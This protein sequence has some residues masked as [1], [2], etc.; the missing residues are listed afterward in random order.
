VSGRGWGRAWDFPV[1]ATNILICTSFSIS[2]NLYSLFYALRPVNVLQNSVFQLSVP[3]I[4]L[5]SCRQ[6]AHTIMIWPPS[7]LQTSLWTW[8]HNMP[9][10]TPLT[11]FNMHIIPQCRSQ[12]PCGLTRRSAV[13]RLLRL[14]VR[15]PPWTWKFVSCECCVLSGRSLCDGLI[16]RT[17]G[18]YRLWWVVVCNLETSWMRRPWPTVGCRA[19]NK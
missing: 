6:L 8:F 19:K 4:C 9:F 3:S 7:A 16:T 15:I 10:L 11:I 17:E 12:W 14:W 1:W 2:F 5:C 13:A 18:S